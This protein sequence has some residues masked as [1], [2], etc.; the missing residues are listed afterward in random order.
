[1]NEK[2]MKI[3]YDF[4]NL[5][6]ENILSADMSD[7]HKKNVGAVSKADIDSIMP[8]LQKAKNKLENKWGKAS[9][10]LAW[11]K[12]M[13]IPE[14]TL[15]GILKT[16]QKVRDNFDYFVVFGIGGSALGPIAVQTALN[17]LRY[18]ELSDEKRPGR[19]STWRTT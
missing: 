16:A 6:E 15:S 3:T 8:E 17:H 5:M 1:M 11:T 4:N 14:A 7:K 12:S 10:M 18:N 2:L 19:S 9:K 13:D